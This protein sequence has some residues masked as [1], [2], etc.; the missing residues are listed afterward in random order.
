MR[1]NNYKASKLKLSFF[2]VLFS[3]SLLWMF[4]NIDAKKLIQTEIQEFQAY[5]KSFS[6]SSQLLDNGGRN[7]STNN[8]LNN[9][10]S[11]VK[12]LIPIVHDGL[13]GEEKD[14]DGKINIFIKFENLE[15]IYSDR[16]K[17]IIQDINVNPRAVPCKI[18]DGI[19]VYKCKVQLKGDL[20]PHWNTKLRMSLKIKV[21][22]GYI[23]GMKE[24]SIQKP[25]ARQFPYDQVF[26]N[27]N[28]DM[29]RL[30]SNGQGFFNITVNGKKWGVMNVEPIIDQTFIE[31]RGLKRSGVFRISNQDS[32]AFNKKSGA[33]KDYFISDPTVNLSQ[34]G[35]EIEILRDPAALEIYSN[36][37]HSLN[38]KDSSLFNR[39]HM[40]GS[41]VLSLAWGN[42]HTLLN[43]NS[44]YTWNSYEQTLEPI[45]TDQMSWQVTSIYLE[46]LND[47]PFEYRMLLEQSPLTLHEFLLEVDK[48][49][50]YFDLNDPVEMVNSLKRGYF[51]NDN[52]FTE[53][54]IY[55]NIDYLKSEASNV[56]DK[57]NQLA[58]T[59]NQHELSSIDLSNNQLKMMGSFVKV[60]HFLDG[61][62]RIHNLLDRDIQLESISVG[63]N[64]QNIKKVIPRSERE[65]INYVDIETNY[66]GDYSKNIN[67]ITSVNGIKRTSQNE[68]SLV[69][70]DSDDVIKK[71]DF[72]NILCNPHTKSNFC[73]I[74]GNHKFNEKVVFSEKTYFEKGTKI[75]LGRGADLI[76]ESSV[77]MIGDPESPILIY[78]NGSGGVYIGNKAGESSHLKNVIF[79][80]LATTSSTLRKYTGSINGYGGI[81]KIE[82]VS[83]NNGKA[84]DQLNLVN[85][86]I[87]ISELEINEAPSDAFD[88]DFCNGY[89]KGLKVMNIQGDGLDVSGS[90]IEVDSF[91][92]NIVADK[93]LS[94]GERSNIKLS[95]AIF[96]NVATGAAVKDSSIAFI[97]DIKLKN[98]THDLFM[99]YIKKPFFIGRTSLEVKNIKTDGA[100][101]GSFCVRSPG[102][103]LT[104]E[105]SECEI[106]NISVDDLYAGR[107]KK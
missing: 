102:T 85:A 26:H 62:I 84:E 59:T 68:V 61:T 18:S 48:L 42:T 44:W 11:I 90:S 71:S 93:A 4:S 86:Q 83:I 53:S 46:N 45:L 41:L 6:Y 56:V 32:W 15:K 63:S 105:G 29:G 21:K 75:F 66:I 82:N 70:F 14:L 94:V 8:Q 28:S 106:S 91:F 52:L 72:K 100:Y 27:V 81:F 57:I 87:E 54:P 55:K 24:F 1:K 97:N 16:T 35:K 58:I 19:K 2:L 95:N 76:F 25:S 101:G 12:K 36:I 67:V 78:G 74:S 88:C 103:F 5:F 89:I 79:S 33:Y 30:S 3:I 99:T 64:I 23:H 20:L 31:E 39:Q 43:N 96:E 77:S 47:L 38:T 49:S 80:D 65:S 22:G 17:A 73:I 69:R 37:F 107:M 50:K 51:H 40:I 9:L 92:A 104:S 7:P 13:V 10:G 98:V 34:R 60:T